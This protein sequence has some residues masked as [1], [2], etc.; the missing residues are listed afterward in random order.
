MGVF[1]SHTEFEVWDGSKTRFWQGTWCGVQALKEAFSDLYSIAS[2]K[3]ASIVDHLE[4]Y[5]GS[6]QWNVSFFRVTHD[7]EVDVFASFFNL[8][9]SLRW[10]GRCRQ[11]LLCP[12][13]KKLF[14]VRSFSNV[15]VPHDV[16][17]FPWRSIWRIKVPLRTTF[18][19][20]LASQWK[21]LT[22]IT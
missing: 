3:D 8:L 18:F 21:I 6:H 12:P 7:W 16:T 20:W 10:D 15:L 5:S 22:W 9:Y 14:N 17:P 1:S 19:A 2:V 11:A 4:L 13:K